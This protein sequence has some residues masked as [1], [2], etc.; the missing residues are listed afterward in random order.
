[1]DQPQPVLWWLG[2]LMKEGV[3][4]AMEEAWVYDHV[5]EGK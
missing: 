1:M 5:N 2:V 4:E 3:P